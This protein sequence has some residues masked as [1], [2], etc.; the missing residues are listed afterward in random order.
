M[1]VVDIS[2]Y[3]AVL[4]WMLSGV[5]LQDFYCVLNSLAAQSNESWRL[6]YDFVKANIKRIEA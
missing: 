3:P 2:L 5:D 1:G 4:E 6:T